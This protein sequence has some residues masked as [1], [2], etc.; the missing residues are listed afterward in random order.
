[1]I[2]DCG[3]SGGK[4]CITLKVG[5][6][7]DLTGNRY[8]Q[9]KTSHDLR[10]TLNKSHKI[11]EEVK[12]LVLDKRVHPDWLADSDIRQL[13]RWQVPVKYWNMIKSIDSSGK[14]YH[15][16]LLDG[17]INDSTGQGLIVFGSVQELRHIIKHTHKKEGAKL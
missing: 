17:F 3:K 16:N 5:Y 10:L 8:I 1:M 2:E 12:R 11:G 14:E 6:V 9:T 7:N 4:Y 15:I 13:E